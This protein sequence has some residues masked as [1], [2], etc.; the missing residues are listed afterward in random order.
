[1]AFKI[2]STTGLL[3]PSGGIAPEEAEADG[4]SSGME[5]DDIVGVVAGFEGNQKFSLRT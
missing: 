3:V 4:I 5:D 1:M 2:P